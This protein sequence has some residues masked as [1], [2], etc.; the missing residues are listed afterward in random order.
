MLWPSGKGFYTFYL[1]GL[2]YCNMLLL[3]TISISSRICWIFLPFLVDYFLGHFCTDCMSIMLRIFCSEICLHKDIQRG[4]SVFEFNVE[5]QARQGP[6]YLVACAVNSTLYE[7][8]FARFEAGQQAA[9]P[10]FNDRCVAVSGRCAFACQSE[11]RTMAN[12]TEVAW[13]WCVSICCLF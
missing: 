11:Q 1:H 12:C 8:S 10:P 5:V 13:H 2:V 3:H 9:P 4:F 7:G 6:L